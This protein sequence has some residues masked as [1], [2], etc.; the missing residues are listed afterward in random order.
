MGAPAA[1]VIN[2]QIWIVTKHALVVPETVSIVDS[3]GANKPG[4]AT[5]S[6]MVSEIDIEVAIK[7]PP[8]PMIPNRL[9]CS[10]TSTALLYVMLSTFSVAF[11][12]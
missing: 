4:K 6:H 12:E 1:S 5:S 10:T 3:D 9:F 8:R 11:H 2:E 7:F